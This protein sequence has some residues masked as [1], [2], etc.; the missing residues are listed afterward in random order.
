M[1]ITNSNKQVNTTSILC[2]E[3]FMVTLSLTA[4]PDITTNPTDIVM[5]LDRSGSM[6]SSALAN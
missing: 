6:A 4:I 1:G 2:N 3:S 5:I